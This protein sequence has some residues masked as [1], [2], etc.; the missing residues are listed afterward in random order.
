M[1]ICLP[2][3]RD[4]KLSSAEYVDI[5]TRL[6]ENESSDDLLVNQIKFINASVSTLTPQKHKQELFNKLFDWGIE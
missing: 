4:G 1:L 6:I 3:V 2:Q 5:F